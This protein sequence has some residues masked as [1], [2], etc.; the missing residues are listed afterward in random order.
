MLTGNFKAAVNHGLM[1]AKM[2]SLDNPEGNLSLTY[3]YLRDFLLAYK[4]LQKVNNPYK[5]RNYIVPDINMGYVYLKNG[6]EKE[7]NSFFK[8]AEK[9]CLLEI[10]YNRINAQNFYSQFY[11]ASIYAAQGEKRK[12]IENLK[13][14]KKREINPLWLVI[15]I[16]QSPYFDNIRQEPEF[17]DI[18]KD[19]ETKYLQ[20]HLL[21][22]ELI[23][24]K[25]FPRGEI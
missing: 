23:K 1:C 22:G 12:A 3:F 6:L 17:A 4:Y 5:L 9:N 8:N 10:K 24:K 16:K 21:I 13:F 20:A 25:D 18:L 14:L 15:D 11:L 19:V 7:A 2:D